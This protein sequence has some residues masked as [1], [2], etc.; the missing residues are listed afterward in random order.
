VVCRRLPPKPLFDEQTADPITDPTAINRDPTAQPVRQFLKHALE[1]FANN[2][3]KT[4]E[5]D[6]S[7]KSAPAWSVS[8]N[9]LP[10]TLA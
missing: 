5:K 8:G 9:A 3:P 4:L 1:Q 10:A 2:K 6:L 7:V